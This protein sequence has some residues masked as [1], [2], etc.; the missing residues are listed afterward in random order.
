MSEINYPGTPRCKD[1]S[2][3]HFSGVVVSLH[4]LFRANIA[5]RNAPLISGRAFTDCI[6]EGPSVMLALSGVNFDSCNLGAIGDDPR[7]LLL[8]PMAS[9]TVVGPIAVRDCSFTR[10]DFLG[11]GY[12]GPDAFIDQMLQALGAS[13]GKPT[14]RA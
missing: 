1:F 7:G 4:E 11:I 12:T 2:V 6:I 10:C 8:M 13:N 3:D 9:H 14:P 5:S